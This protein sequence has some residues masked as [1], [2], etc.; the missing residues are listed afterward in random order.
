M[1]S[2]SLD[3]LFRAFPDDLL[4]TTVA[5]DVHGCTKLPRPVKQIPGVPAWVS[6]RH[7]EPVVSL[8]RVA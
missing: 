4:L 3:R 2:I 5:N 1:Q 7:G 8:K 6:A